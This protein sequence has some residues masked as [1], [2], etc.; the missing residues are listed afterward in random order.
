M[1]SGNVGI[2]TTAPTAKLAVSGDMTVGKTSA[3]NGTLDVNGSVVMS[4]STSGF[5]GFR[6]AAVGGSTIWS[7]PSGDGTSGQVL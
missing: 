5:N 2:G 4:G 1:G 6:A 3:A 7:L